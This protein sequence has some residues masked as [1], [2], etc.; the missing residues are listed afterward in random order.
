M[1]DARRPLRPTPHLKPFPPLTVPPTTGGMEEREAAPV[2]GFTSNHN[3]V[4]LRCGEPQMWWS[5]TVTMAV[6]AGDS[7]AKLEERVPQAGRE[8]MRR[9]LAVAVRAREAYQIQQGGCPRCAD[10]L[11]VYPHGT[12]RCVVLT[13]CG[14]VTLAPRP[15]RAGGGARTIPALKPTS[16]PY[17]SVQLLGSSILA[18]PTLPPPGCPGGAAPPRSPRHVRGSRPR[19]TWHAPVRHLP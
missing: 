1:G 19:D 18:R 12:V 2:V 13:R 8:A 7:I 5:V 16:V 10:G 14:R 4:S 15:K 6:G 11:P 3:G 9:T 17:E